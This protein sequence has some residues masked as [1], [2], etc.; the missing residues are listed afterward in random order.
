MDKRLISNKSLA[1]YQYLM[2]TIWTIY[3]EDGSVE[4]QKDSMIPEL[5]NTKHD[6]VILNNTIKNDVYLPDHILWDETVS[7]EAFHTIW[8]GR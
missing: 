4:I 5:E 6:Y 8:S 1:N 3:L 2:D 7:L